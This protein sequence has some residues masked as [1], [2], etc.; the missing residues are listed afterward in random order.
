VDP[1]WTVSTKEDLQDKLVAL[2]AS[3]SDLAEK[4]LEQSNDIR[5]DDDLLALLEKCC[6]A[7]P[8]NLRFDYLFGR[9]MKVNLNGN[10]FEERL[11]DRD[12]G[13]GAAQDAVERVRKGEVR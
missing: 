11:Y 9:V 1:W 10:S 4:Y 3:G 6:D 12:N 2:A 8:P 7:W 13:P 5:T